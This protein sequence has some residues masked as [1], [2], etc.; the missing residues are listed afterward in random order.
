M[1][2]HGYAQWRLSACLILAV[3]GAAA[4]QATDRQAF[5]I[6]NRLTWGV[7]TAAIDD[8]AAPG[9]ARW[10]DQQL[11]PRSD[12]RLPP[13]VE[14]QI[15]G[16]EIGQRPL[17]A[18][19]VE[20]D[21]QKKAAANADPAQKQAAYAA[22]FK[23]G[24]AL[25]R[26]AMMRLVLRCLYGRDQL[27]QQMTWFWLNHFS[28]FAGKGDVGPMIGDYEDRAIRPYALG[29][30]RDLLGATLRHPAML[31]YLDNG[32]NSA[33]HINENYAR[34]L[35]ELHSMGVG[36]GYSQKDVQELARILT[37][38]GVDLN[39]ADPKLKDAWQP[40]FVRG[41]LFEFNPARHDFG[42]KVFLGHVIKGSGFAEVEQALDLIAASPATAHFVSG[43]LATFFLGAPPSPE[44]NARLAAVFTRSRGDIAAVLGSLFASAE[45]RASLGHA[46]KDPV[47]Y[48]LSSIRLAY[49]DRPIDNPAVAI[50]LITGLG[51]GLFHRDTPDGWPLEAAA[52][53]GPGQ[54][55][56]RFDFAQRLGRGFIALFAPADPARP[57]PIPPDIRSSPAG[58]AL[59]EGL[60]SQTRAAL[61]QAN[62][63]T[64]WNALFLSSPEFM[65]R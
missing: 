43:K 17:A 57:R 25:S 59:Q 41:G 23:R 60:S 55:A 64:D 34:E 6:A 18:I 48:V 24:D 11:H 53:S 7:G 56:A 12:P 13:P 65:R 2:A 38:V 44:L 19:I 49:G 33:G 1:M 8:E 28:V 45:F 46:F 52:W 32:V 37:G 4:A 16:F 47:H 14:V 5:A 54:M 39:P 3:S 63:A 36:S 21:A 51:Q 27:R 58:A 50:D 10:I 22:Y 42:D 61:A 20:L 35:M 40:L 31:R 15:A 29:R 9:S 62:N 26:Q 30:F